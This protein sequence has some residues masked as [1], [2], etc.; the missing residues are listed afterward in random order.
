[1][2]HRTTNDKRLTTKAKFLKYLLLVTCHLSIVFLLSGCSAVG[3]NKPAALQVTSVPEASIFLDG[4]HIGKTPFFSDQIKSGE[5]LL[6]I[7]ASEASYVDKIV[8]TGG[9]LTVVNR[10]LSN[11]F[12]AQS[13]ETLWLDSG[14]RGLFVSSLPG[15]ANMT[16]NGRLIGKTPLLVDEIEDGEHKI[17][18]TKEGFIDREFT[19]KASSKYQVMANV[20]LASEVAK[21]PQSSPVP[22]PQIEKVKVLATSLGFLR[23]RR[24]PSLTA[25]EIGRVKTGDELEVVQETKDWVQVKFAGKQGWISAQYAKKL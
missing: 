23:V 24:E 12:L 13:G 3:S 2:P 18:L 9:T 19:I 5:Y 25:A 11:N 6:K 1:M 15:E 4:K 8:L 16:I 14:K 20:T 17:T 7:T 22:L 21:T 10:E